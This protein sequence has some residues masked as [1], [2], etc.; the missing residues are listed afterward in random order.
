MS[1]KDDPE[2]AF[3]RII[4]ESYPQVDEIWVTFD[5]LPRY[6]I[7]N[8]GRVCNRETGRD[9][10]PSRDKNG[11]LKVGLSHNGTKH[12]VYVHRLV[13]KAFFLNYKN[14]I[15][16][17]HINGDKSDCSVLNL[18]LGGKCRTGWF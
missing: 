11:Y 10:T 9:L 5:L 2:E 6:E 3:Y 18:T 13:A 15:E 16:V 8:Y 14:G 1:L 7:S 12:Y 17:K 4:G